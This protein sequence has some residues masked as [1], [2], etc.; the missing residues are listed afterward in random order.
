LDRRFRL[1]ADLDDGTGGFLLPVPLARSRLGRGCGG[2]FS[3]FSSSA[4]R[5]WSDWSSC[6]LVLMMEHLSMASENATITALREHLRRE[7]FGSSERKRHSQEAVRASD[8]TV[9]IVW[10]AYVERGLEILLAS[11]MT[12]TA[13]LRKQVFGREG[14][15]ASFSAKIIVAHAL[16]LIDSDTKRNADYV[17]EIRNAFAHTIQNLRFR[18]PEVTALYDLFMYRHELADFEKRSARRRFLSA[19]LET[20]ETIISTWT[21]APPVQQLL[22]SLE[23]PRKP[24]PLAS[25]GRGKGKPR[26]PPQA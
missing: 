4:S 22:P 16:G 6:S 2:V 17:R 26:R 5:R 1:P 9:A 18:T 15:L 10:G 7:T 3:N 8:R 11:R 21:H 23:K 19:A 14:P 24:P 20:A 25:R 13:T 12:L